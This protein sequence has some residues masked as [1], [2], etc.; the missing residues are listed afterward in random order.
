MEL[1]TKPSLS[2]EFQ[3]SAMWLRCLHSSGRYISMRSPK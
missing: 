2:P 1:V 3:V